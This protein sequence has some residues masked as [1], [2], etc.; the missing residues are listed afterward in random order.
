[1]IDFLRKFGKKEKQKGNI[2]TAVVVAAGSSSRMEGLDKMLLLLDGKPVLAHTLVALNKCELIHEII[3]VT[4]EDL[5]VDIGKLCKEF[6]IEKAT[7][8]LVGGAERSHSVLI[9]VRDAR[10]DASLIAIHD[11]A[12]PFISEKLLYDVLVS[13]V[14]TGASAPAIPV[15]DTIKKAED[16]LVEETL[17]REK[18]WAV[19]TPQVFESSLIKGALEEAVEKKIAITDDCSA[20]ERLGMKV[21]LTKGSSRN[22]KITTPLDLFV[23]ERILAQNEEDEEEKEGN[24]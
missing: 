20:V 11:G 4:R 21:T 12:R 5:M 7:K 13:A 9:G 22:I 17:P 10:E 3:V 2:C 8:V 6:Q 1:M 16:G 18:L 24:S 14:R 19:Q 23:A 15:T